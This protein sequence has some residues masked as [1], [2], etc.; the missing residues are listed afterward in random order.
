[1]RIN[2]RILLITF[3]LIVLISIPS[4]YVYY[5]ITN[6]IIQTQSSNALLNSSNDF[7]FLLESTLNKVKEDFKEFVAENKDLNT[8]QFAENNI[9]F[10]FTLDENNLINHNYFMSKPS[11]EL[12]YHLK[13]LES[14]VELNPNAI[15]QFENMTNGGVVFYGFVIDQKFLDETS[16]RIRSE[17]VLIINDLPFLISNSVKTNSDQINIIDAYNKLKFKNNY[18]YHLQEESRG[19]LIAVIYRPKD[20]ISSRS[21]INFLVYSRFTEASEFRATMRVVVSLIIVTGILLSLIFAMVF[22]VKIRKQISLLYEAVENTKK[23]N[24]NFRVPIISQD[25]LG[26]FG[27]SYNAM[28]EELKIKEETEKSYS[29]FM[30]I[31]NRQN[32]LDEVASASM[33][34]ILNTTGFKFGA[35]YMVENKKL[36]MIYSAGIEKELLEHHNDKNIYKNVVEKAET[37]E[38]QFEDNYPV[39]R[40]AF[41][42]I[43][44][45][46]LLVSPLIYNKQ[47]IGVLEIASEHNPGITPLQYI[48]MVSDQLAIGLNNAK[49]FV[50]LTHFVN[51]LRRLNE[52]Y[53]KQN[54]QIKNQNRELIELHTQLREKAKE[55]EEEK[56]KAV[57]L[58]HVKSQFLAS[59]S[60]ELR[61]PLNSIIGLTELIEHDQATIPKNKDRLKIVLRNGKRLLAL[62]NNILEFSKIE[63]GK[64]EVKQSNFLLSDLLNEIYSSVEPIYFDKEIDVKFS[65]DSKKDFL[66]NSDKNKLEHILINL[67]TNAIKFTD[68]G[69]V[70]IIAKRDIKNN[71]SF[72]VKDSGIGLNEEQIKIIFEEF[73]KLEGNDKRKHSGAGLGLAIC[74]KYAALLGSEIK[75]E[76]QPQRGATFSLTLQN[77]ILDVISITDKSIYNFLGVSPV[78]E[79][80]TNKSLKVTAAK[81]KEIKRR[82]LVVDDDTDT[83]FT[84]GEILQNLDY[85]I[86]FAGNGVECLSQIEKVLPAVILLDIMMPQMDGFETI[87]RIRSND[88]YS[89]ICVIALTAHAMIEDKHILEQSGFNDL[90]TKPIDRNILQNKITAALSREKRTTK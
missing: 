75:V 33:E 32:S 87:K 25:E 41:L 20:I 69:T 72:V 45:K 28:L 22:T 65:V 24:L 77:A 43:K 89:H 70:E 59:M 64:Y 3:S 48:R 56:T 58:T 14:F 21:K 34:K 1:M 5:K 4:S 36:S 88:A 90:I 46:Y 49:A 47:V 40:S 60:H 78:L 44:I 76:S 82:I 53:L 26:H 86:S 68:S 13:T 57:E 7:A 10:L 17:I 39:L 83:L 84:V 37:I 23:G 19:D 66:I 31:I 73:V 18:D 15:L 38:L 2:I 50:Q 12:N 55:L 71:L 8:F 30:A 27:E 51:E 80:T 11:V 52:E 16:R 63:S 79:T 9:D 54:E 81:S 61:T 35:L 29:E 85:D 67:V 74:K 62:I 6:S 42:E